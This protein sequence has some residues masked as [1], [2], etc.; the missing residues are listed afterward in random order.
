M[1]FVRGKSRCACRYNTRYTRGWGSRE[2]RWSP[3]TALFVDK[4][5]TQQ[6]ISRAQVTSSEIAEEERREIQQELDLIDKRWESGRNQKVVGRAKR[7]LL[8][9]EEW[10]DIQVEM[11]LGRNERQEMDRTQKWKRFGIYGYSGDA[12]RVTALNSG[13][14]T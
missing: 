10:V 14:E 1:S 3:L 6:D 8:T 9:S 4:V 11:G 7:P 5:S 2:D 12:R 13:G